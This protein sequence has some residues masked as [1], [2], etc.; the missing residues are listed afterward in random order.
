MQDNDVEHYP[1]CRHCGMDRRQFASSRILLSYTDGTEVAFCSIHCLAIDLVLNTDKTPKSIK[2]AD[3]NT[4]V[5]IDAETASWV[6]GGIKKGVMTER[7]KW[8]FKSGKDAEDFIRQNGG[9]R[10]PFEQTLEA[11]Y[12]DMY[13]DSKVIRNKRK[14]KNMIKELDSGNPERGARPDSR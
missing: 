10:T 2:V 3:Y 9:E 1:V 14:I 7:A 8:A 6:L 12:H 5:L 13:T 11:A 4:R